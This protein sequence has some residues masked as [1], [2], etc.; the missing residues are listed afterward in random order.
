MNKPVIMQILPALN[1]GGVER[2]TIEMATALKK[3][4]WPNFVV[5]AGGKLTSE[6]DKLGVEH[7]TLP[8]ASKNPL[9]MLVNVLILVQIIKEK[10]V[11]IIHAR[12]RAPAW[13][14]YWASKITKVPFLTTFHGVY[15]IGGSSLKKWYNSVMTRGKLIIA[16]SNFVGR[17]IQE[18]YGI[19]SDK[20]RVIHRGADI[21][22]FN[23]SLVSAER[24]TAL[25]QKWNLKKDR[26]IIMLPGRLTRWK[27]QLVLLEALTL[28][29]NKNCFCLFLG[30]DQ[31]RKAYSQEL[32]DYIK[33][34][35]LIGRVAFVDSCSDMP[36]AYRFSDVVVSASTDPEAF[37]RVIP[38]AQAMGCLVVASRHGGATETIEP[39][40]TGLFA[41]VGNASSLAGALDRLLSM[42]EADKEKMIADS[43]DSVRSD[44]SVQKMCEKTLKVYEELS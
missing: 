8:V 1:Q 13:S 10:K 3:A 2:G 34:N 18:N 26:P 33:K 29:E 27:G 12:S 44:F 31:G 20:I 37:G 11:G 30:S 15:N 40:K 32:K 42:N 19:S 5:S 9:R 41:E 28:M 24:I 21:E 43:I 14:A 23:P 36:A 39:E 6:L 22:K 16:V 7:I 38:E 25:L 35:G 17:H 4:N